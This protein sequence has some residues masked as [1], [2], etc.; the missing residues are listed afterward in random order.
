LNIQ[1]YNFYGW[2]GVQPPNSKDAYPATKNYY[3]RN[4]TQAK[5]E[6]ESEGSAENVLFSVGGA[7]NYITANNNTSATHLLTQDITNYYARGFLTIKNY[8]KNFL[9]GGNINLNLESVADNAQNYFQ[10]DGSVSYFDNRIS[11]LLKGGFQVANNYSDTYRGGALL[12]GNVEYRLNKLFTIKANVFSG[13]EKTEFEN[14]ISINP[15]LSNRIQIDHRYD[16]ANVKGAL[17]Y[18]P[19]ENILVSGGVNW[20]YS[21]RNV[22]YIYDTLAEF[23]LGY[24][25]GNVIDIF[26]EALWNITTNDRFIGKVNFNIN[27]MSDGNYLTY[28]PVFKVGSTYHRTMWKNFKAFVTLELIGGQNTNIINDKNNKTLDPYLILNFGADYTIK[29]IN[30]FIKIN[31]IT[32]TD[33]VVWDRYRERGFFGALGII[34][35]F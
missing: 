31:N 18:H 29:P 10:A 12:Y 13:L 19:N 35:M 30:I 28:T 24:V 2:Y 17:W 11:V 8:W 4:L 32:N 14:L 21:E 22:N 9:I 25:D 33:Y 7:A 34:F 27:D 26:G 1:N 3:D 15:Y 23:K 20:R 5:F 6:I 16:I